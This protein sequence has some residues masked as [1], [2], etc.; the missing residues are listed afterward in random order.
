[1]STEY[2]VKMMSSSF[3]RSLWKT[4]ATL[5]YPTIYYPFSKIGYRIHAKTFDSS[6]LQV[7]LTGKVCLVT[8]ANSGI[9]YETARALAIRNAQ[10]WLLCRNRERG[11]DA[12][13]KIQNIT[14]NPQVF[15]EILDVSKVESIEDFIGRF[16]EDQVDILVNN[17]GALP[18]DF[19]L[20]EDGYELTL[21]TNLVGTYLLTEMLYPKLSRSSHSRVLNISSGGM[22]VEKLNLDRLITEENTFSSIRTYAQ[23]KRALVVLTEI[24]AQKWKDSSI[25]VNS[26]HPG[27]A[28]TPALKASLT[29][30]WK[31]TRKK[32]RTPQE[33]ADTIIWMSLSE[34][35][36]NVSGK[37]F[38]D[39]KARRTHYLPWTQESPEERERL[40]SYLETI[41]E[42]HSLV[43]EEKK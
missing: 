23:T 36:K 42:K 3:S 7:D 8:G 19:V 40:K 17:A 31:F 22:Y 5:L 18:H 1:M 30:F 26:M 12:L 33:G 43:V 34:K 11:L 14:K 32:L 6:E 16:D 20:T 9:G 28:D 35:L 41:L 27:W 25:K 24:W 29:T 4:I 2:Q 15:L 10:V 21:V 37:F 13:R 38:F 39:R